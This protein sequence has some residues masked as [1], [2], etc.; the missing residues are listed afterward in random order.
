M[1]LSN[2]QQP[3]PESSRLI[4]PRIPELVEREF[5]KIRLD[6]PYPR[7][8]VVHTHKAPPTFQTDTDL[9]SP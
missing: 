6:P 1:N 7:A 8:F 2:S 3:I 4:I 9:I 5:D